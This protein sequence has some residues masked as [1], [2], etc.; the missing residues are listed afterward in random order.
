M[1]PESL[2]D[3]RVLFVSGI[4]GDTRRYRC[5]HHQE[6]LAIEGIESALR[7]HDDP[8]LVVD[9]LNY[10]LFVLHRVP[11][12][13]LIAAVIDIARSRGKPVVFETDDLV[14]DP[15]LY[16]QIGFVDT[17][18]V[19]QARA[20]RTELLRLTETFQRCDCVLTTTQFLADEARQRSKPAYVHRNVPSREMVRISEEAFAA[21]QERRV[22]Q[23][24]SPTV[25]GF[26]S[27]TGSHN[28]DFQ[29]IAASLTRV[30]EA[31]PRV[32]LH[33]SGH[34]ELGPQFAPLQARIRRA[35]YISWRELPHV[36]ARV[37][38]NLAPLEPENPF[39]RAK[40]EIKFV[41]AAL[42]GV[43]TI[44]SRVDAYQ[45]A[46]THG[47][48]SL[49]AASPEDWE[50]ALRSLLEDPARRA[51]LGS[52]ARRTAYA[53]Y[54]PEQRAAELRQTLGNV[55]HR[56]GKPPAP[57]EQIMEQVARSLRSY[58]ESMHLEISNR[59][60]QFDSLR[61][62]IEQYECQLEEL[63]SVHNRLEERKKQLE[64]TK[65]RVEELKRHI[66]EIRQGRVMR[67]VAAV[68]GVLDKFR[69]G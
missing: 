24:Q 15:A 28:R 31:H 4:D 41:E 17:L 57:P 35:P 42:V 22:E 23:D 37:D 11:Y 55:L 64:A 49:L 13:P 48:N 21:Q 38:I 40:S 5:F 32:L 2:S 46:I 44:A 45:L 14:F 16:D 63:E 1:E 30:M 54:M 19:E 27:G 60:A 3:Q 68:N 34:L 58:A 20:Y 33:I 50:S 67:A 59:E 18:S 66:E 8:S 9:V 26:F 10:D 52:A 51:A 47:E 29:T 65:K 43:P 6:Q 61:R 39:C 25:I 7:E 69:R 36:I 56:F 62:M 12:T 53:R